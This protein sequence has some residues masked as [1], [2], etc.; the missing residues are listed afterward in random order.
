MS[1]PTHDETT[2]DTTTTTASTSTTVGTTTMTAAAVAARVDAELTAL[3]LRYLDLVATRPTTDEGHARRCAAMALISAR[4][5]G[6][7]RVLTT[8]YIRHGGLH[9]LF[10]RAA[11]GALTRERSDARF[12]RESAQDWQARVD[13]RPTSDAAGALSNWTELG[14]TA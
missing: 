7:W 13:A 12:W 10:Y 3:M 6:W 4:R 2:H 14:V 11:L 8:Y 5:A 9:P 1:T